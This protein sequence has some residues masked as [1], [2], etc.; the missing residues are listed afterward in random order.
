MPGYGL[1]SAPLPGGRKPK[2]QTEGVHR[3]AEIGHGCPSE[4][5]HS[6]KYSGEICKLH[7]RGLGYTP[8]HFA[9]NQAVE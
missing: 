2:P 1:S 3:R 8:E 7:F 6:H 5:K 4:K 9:G